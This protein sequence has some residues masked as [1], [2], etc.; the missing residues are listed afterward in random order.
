M[1]ISEKE[2][3]RTKDEPSGWKSA[4][5]TPPLTPVWPETEETLVMMA[6]AAEE[7]VPVRVPSSPELLK[8]CSPDVLLAVAETLTLALVVEAL[9]TDWEL[10]RVE[11]LLLPVPGCCGSDPTKEMEPTR[12]RAETRW[13]SFTAGYWNWEECVSVLDPVSEGVE[14]S[15][16]EEREEGKEERRLLY[17]STSFD[18]GVWDAEGAYERRSPARK[19]DAMR[20]SGIAAQGGEG[21]RTCVESTAR[22][23]A[24]SWR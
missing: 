14:W 21:G 5:G 10:E 1:K 2:R 18:G 7:A 12:E 16:E 4:G 8:L 6:V 24:K 11:P 13:R 15:E 22:K 19:A 23:V 9:E 3:K 20:E 17:H